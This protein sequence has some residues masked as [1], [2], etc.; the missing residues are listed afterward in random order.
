MDDQFGS[1]VMF[2]KD[3]RLSRYLQDSIKMSCK[4][5]RWRIWISFC[6]GE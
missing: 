1:L 6:M 5:E 4:K 2:G 3:L